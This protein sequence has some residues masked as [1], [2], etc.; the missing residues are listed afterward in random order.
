MKL[1]YGNRKYAY[2]PE[3]SSKVWEAAEDMPP[4]QQE[5]GQ[6]EESKEGQRLQPCPCCGCFTIPPGGEYTAY[7]CPVCFW[8]MDC[9][10][11]GPEEPSDQNHGLTLIQAAR[12]YRKYG[13]VLPR[14]KKYCRP[15]ESWELPL[16]E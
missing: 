12:N 15:P 8:E 7:I 3:A 2:L 9:F 13:A 4:A 11:Q 14:L 6:G 16:E 10:I 1:K 5:E